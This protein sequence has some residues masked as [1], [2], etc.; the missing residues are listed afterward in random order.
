ME[1]FLKVGFQASD[2]TLHASLSPQSAMD[3]LAEEVVA[4]KGGRGGSAAGLSLPS[5]DLTLWLCTGRDG[6]G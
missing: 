6:G 3:S 5:A 4:L 1:Y 2:S